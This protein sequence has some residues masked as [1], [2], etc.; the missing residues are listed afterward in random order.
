VMQQ[1]SAFAKENTCVKK[2]LL[3]LYEQMKQHVSSGICTST[4]YYNNL[5]EMCGIPICLFFGKMF[6]TEKC[7]VFMVQFQ[8]TSLKTS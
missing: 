2:N 3:Q 8:Y 1:S 4:D 6:H 7:G 5:T